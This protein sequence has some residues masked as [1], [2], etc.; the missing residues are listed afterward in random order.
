MAEK[1]YDISPY[2]YCAGN[3][4]NLLDPD[5]K[6]FHKKQSV[7]TIIVQATYCA[8]IEPCHLLIH[9]A[10]ALNHL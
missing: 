1:Y 3:P 10:L 6:R 4:V 5:G 9:V 2:V 7:N 8:N